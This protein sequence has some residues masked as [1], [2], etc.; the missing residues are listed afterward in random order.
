MLTTAKYT[1]KS[2]KSWKPE[3]GLQLFLGGA[4]EKYFLLA[5]N[6][7]KCTHGRCFKLCDSILTSSRRQCWDTGDA[8]NPETDATLDIFMDA[9]SRLGLKAPPYFLLHFLCSASQVLL[10]V[11][12]HIEPYPGRSELS[13]RDDLMHIIHR[14]GQHKALYR[15]SVEDS[16]PVV[17]IYDRYT[18]T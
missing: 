6:A 1:S 13:V 3:S 9:C 14:F 8:W 11:S 18:S 15:L 5:N 17:Y 7:L 16:R 4:A 2:L 10:Q 12:F